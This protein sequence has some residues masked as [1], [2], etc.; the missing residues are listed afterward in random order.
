MR[1][2]IIPRNGCFINIMKNDFDFK[3]AKNRH[4]ELQYEFETNWRPK[5]DQNEREHAN[6]VKQFE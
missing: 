4:Q 5:F 3:H 1:V 2:F 6:N